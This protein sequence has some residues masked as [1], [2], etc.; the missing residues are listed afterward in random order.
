MKREILKV[1]LLFLGWR[2]VLFLLGLLADFILPYAPS[3]PYSDTLLAVSHLPRA[4]YSWANF[5]GVHYITIAREGYTHVRFIQAFFPLFPLLI[6]KS[7]LFG[8]TLANFFALGA[9]LIWFIFCKYFFGKR[10]AWIAVI[11]WLLF[12]TSLFLGALYSEGLFLMLAL[13]SFL[14]AAKKKWL[15]AGILVALASATRIIGIFLV[16]AL[17]LELYL[18][19]RDTKFQW[20]NAGYILLGSFGLIAYMIYLKLAVGDPLA[21]FHAQS[22][23]GAGRQTTLIIYPQVIWRAIKILL[24]S[25]VDQRFLIYAQ[26][27][28]AG[29]L[30]LVGII[31][32]TKYARPSWIL[33]SLCAFFLPTLTGTF[34]SMGR[35]LLV[36]FPLFLFLTHL[37]AHH[38]KLGILWIVISAFLLLMNTV[39]FIQGY[40]V[41]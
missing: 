10:T 36:C 1:V 15:A 2:I 20:R 38:K 41:A 37:T 30:G 32:G 23:F 22:A 13:S 5:D 28:L 31:L 33:F 18:Q 40:W 27:F 24:T 11:V 6:S 17:L 19:S 9:T 16:P 34:S 26:E 7:I 39:L 35:Y 4:I 14:L 3:F 25:P 21:F 12:P 29:T 8:V